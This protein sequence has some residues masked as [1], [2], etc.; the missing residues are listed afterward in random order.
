ME[1]DSG[2]ALLIISKETF[3][4]ICAVK[5]NRRLEPL[6]IQL[7]DFQGLHV[8]VTGMGT[9]QVDYQKSS[10]PLRLV[11]VEGHC[12]NLLGLGWFEPLAITVLGIH[13][14]DQLNAEA[15]YQESP[16][17]FNY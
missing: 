4:W 15:I 7:M 12:T 14:V 11:V 10:A 9:F 16:S 17:A 3:R 5:G 6:P 13:Q 8:P 1:V 2:S